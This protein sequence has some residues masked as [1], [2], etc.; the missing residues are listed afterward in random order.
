M[1]PRRLVTP[2]IVLLSLA[3]VA[4]WR[5][6]AGNAPVTVETADVRRSP[7]E[8]EWSAVGYVEA[9]T[10]S[11]SSPSVGTVKRVLVREGDR[12]VA[13]QPL[14]I[15]EQASETAAVRAA[16]AGALM[17]E[18][19]Q[20][21]GAALLEEA[22]SAQDARE[23]RALAELAAARAREAQARASLARAR[24]A[25]AASVEAARAEALAAEAGLRDLEA[26]A[27]SEEIARAD[28]EVQAAQAAL[29][30]SEAELARLEE[31]EAAGAASK[32]DADAAREAHARSAATLR[33]AQQA[34][35][36]LRRGARRDQIEAARA[37]AAAAKAQ[38]RAAEADMKAIGI[39]EQQAAEATSARRAA[40]AAVA[41]AVAA[42]MRV[43]ATENDA[44]AARNR[45]EQSRAAA[46]QA[47]AILGDRRIVA[48]FSGIVGRR[49]VDPGDMASPGAALFTIV[50]D[51]RTWVVAE[52]DEQ[53]L[54][55]V[56]T[57]HE[58]VVSATAYVGREFRGRVER[59][60]GEAVPQTEVRTGARIVR[61]RVSL[62][63]LAAPER[64]M[65]KPGMEVHVSGKAV[66]ATDALLVPSDAVAVSDHD[67]AVWVVEGERAHRRAVVTGCAGTQETEIRSGLKEG[68]RVALAGKET[69]TEN[70]R[71]RARRSPR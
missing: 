9:R 10:A 66:M 35:S 22:R 39:E 33:S 7:L 31:L 43:A 42:R 32:R 41:E 51:D 49:F 69:L 70:V 57:G 67:S 46:Q 1:K 19:Q 28:A 47:A 17:A 62:D 36:L 61:V 13:G 48:P 60:A 44:K 18:A 71:V 21:A 53:D 6:Y 65:L 58:V 54:A 55:P 23:H 4:V 59:I 40:E 56:R 50:E 2:I 26:P 52:V 64:A 68:E 8:V 5:M 12:V 25:R 30:R 3:A 24:E 29:R 16:R 27:R 38:L 37:K 20:S 63:G 45:A 14:A 11:V 15:L 34:A